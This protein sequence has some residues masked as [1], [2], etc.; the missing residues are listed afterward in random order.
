MADAV[1]D[2]AGSFPTTGRWNPARLA[3]T[4]V[5]TGLAGVV[6]FG[7]GL[8]QALDLHTPLLR[9]WTM[10]SGIGVGV[11]K[12]EFEVTD[13]S[14]TTIRMR[15]LDVL[16]LQRYPLVR[17]FLFDRLVSEPGDLRTFGARLCNDQTTRVAFHGHTGTR[18][19]W[20]P[21]DVDDICGLTV[22]TARVSTNAGD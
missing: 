8:R 21:L 17:S 14:G 20:V 6:L 12:G 2:G 9:Q 5:F 13:A 18:Q 1:A 3:R 4:L 22:T 7:P 16:E 15:P 11:L 19:G 10:F